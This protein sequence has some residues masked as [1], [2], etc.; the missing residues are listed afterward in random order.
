MSVADET[1]I[2]SSVANGVTTSFPYGFTVLDEGDL[3]V[4]GL[5]PGATSA[6]SYTYGVHYTLTGVG[7]ASG[8][9]EFFVAPA[10]GIV[11]T[12][13]RQSSLTRSTDYQENGDLLAQTVNKDFDRLWHAAQDLRSGAAAAANSLRVP[14]GETMAE[15]PAAA[16]RLDRLA[17][18]DPTT[19][20]PGVSSFTATQVASAV[21][22]AYAAGST[23]DAVTFLQAGAGVR[24]RS[25]QE[26]LREG[27]ISIMEIQGA[28]ADGVTDISPAMA[29]AAATGRPV[30]LPAGNYHFGTAYVPPPGTVL[31]LIG[32]HADLVTITSA[33]GIVPLF[34]NGAVGVN[35]RIGGAY[36]SGI[37]FKG[38]H[39]RTPASFPYN[40]DP[41]ASSTQAF[42]LRGTKGNADRA[43]VVVT[44]CIFE[45]FNGL[46]F[47][48][49]DF[50]G[51]VRVTN[52]LFRR[53]KDPGI[54]MCDDVTFAF[55][56]VEYSADNGV[57]LSRSNK[58]V[59]VC[60]NLI[61]ECASS[62]IF[63]GGVN[64]TG[65][66]GSLT[67]TGAAYTAGSTVTL[68][69][70]ANTFTTED[71]GFTF[72]LRSGS[73]RGPVRIVS[74]AS[75]TQATAVVLRNIPASLQAV[76][77]ADWARGP[78]SGA[79]AGSVFCNVI[80]GAS[81]YGIHLSQGSKDL[82][83]SHNVIRRTGITGDS[84]VQTRGTIALSTNTLTVDSAAG[85]AV[86]DWIVV[87]PDYTAEDYFIAKILGKAG[88]VLTLNA[89]PPQTLVNERVMRA[90]R[91]TA[92]YG[93]L[94]VGGYESATM[95]EFAENLAIMSN[96]I[97]DSVTG[98]MRLGST[99]GSIR[100]SQVHKNHIHLRQNAH[101]ETNIFGILIG[102]Q[103]TT[104]M[105]TVRLDVLE[106]VISLDGTGIGIAY[107]PVDNS[108]DS[109]IRL[110]DN[111]IRQVAT[112]VQVVEQTGSTDI[113][114]D[115][116][117]STYGGALTNVDLVNA[118]VI[119]LTYWVPATVSVNTMTVTKTLNSY[120]PG[121]ATTINDIVVS[122]INHV[123]PLIVIRNADSTNS[124]TFTHNMSKIR[125]KGGAN[126]TVPPGGSI[127]FVPIT[128][129][130]VQQIA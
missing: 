38:G 63:V 79:Q 112:P 12:R 61:R 22:A 23:A 13:F 102:D 19:G 103:G 76:A 42:N 126:V 3:V 108:A 125:T 33:P 84:E 80:E 56:V 20:Q 88:N 35:A 32:E 90:Y 109:H 101:V 34:C 99:S 96:I 69:S 98:G 16:G 115:Y 104:A 81:N 118:D 123:T 77:T 50:D 26:K 4:T 82:T 5:A 128:T 113:T 70:T 75:Q 127:T 51:S 68:T 15:L 1:P 57:S 105:R 29:T 74:V 93:L 58:R 43:S 78:I 53:T 73:D 10:S 100:D 62:G 54:L 114:R 41:G 111:R 40:A 7:T 121:G 14:V 107:R 87:D 120:Q 116:M 67:V 85:F 52:N 31:R 72:T 17:T 71:E 117:P 6:T 25:V 55:N 59:N 124:I 44:D 48:I 95:L 36:I 30:Y 27:A 2:A 39:V 28:A 66:T 37:K 60:F 64:L 8:S 91:R 94:A 65:S 130:I 129:S 11:V 97:V 47:W 122:G 86:G 89:A 92:A 46:P 18:F 83:V 49:A 21:A 119:G 106:N 110:A 45:D 9:V 24:S